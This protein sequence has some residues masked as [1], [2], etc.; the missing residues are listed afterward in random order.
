MKLIVMLSSAYAVAF[1]GLCM[2]SGN[3]V[4]YLTLKIRKGPQELTIPV[5]DVS[6]KQSYKVGILLPSALD[7]VRPPACST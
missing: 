6:S 5:R 2:E 1:C 4:G 7:G 3:I